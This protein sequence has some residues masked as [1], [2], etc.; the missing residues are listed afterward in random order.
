MRDAAHYRKM[1]DDNPNAGIGFTLAAAAVYAARYGVCEA[2]QRGTEEWRA[3]ARELK[4]RYGEN[5]TI[6]QVVREMSD[7][8][9]ED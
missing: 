8:T 7:D 9:E 2:E 5:L 4:H 3:I 6:E 1:F